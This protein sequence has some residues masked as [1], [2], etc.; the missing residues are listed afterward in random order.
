[1]TISLSDLRKAEKVQACLGLGCPLSVPADVTL[2]L[3]AIARA[4]LAWS[5]AYSEMVGAQYGAADS[6]RDVMKRA[7]ERYHVACHSLIDATTK[8]TP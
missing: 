6:S 2:R 3:V 7:A 5:E 8:G 4:A 1:M